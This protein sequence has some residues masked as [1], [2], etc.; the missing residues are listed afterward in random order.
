VFSVRDNK[1]K[2]SN[3]MLIFNIGELP[4]LPKGKGNKIINIP[5]KSFNEEKEYMMDICCL[6]EDSQLHIHHQGKTGGKSWTLKELEGYFSV[7]AKRGKVLPSGYNG[8][9]K[10]QEIIKATEADPE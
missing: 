5:T 8:Q 10:L 1:E 9:I 6:A 3:K 2:V 4:F 7:R